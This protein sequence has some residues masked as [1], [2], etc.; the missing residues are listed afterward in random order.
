[1]FLSERLR[2]YNIKQL[3]VQVGYQSEWFRLL[4]IESR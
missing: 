1:M 2:W 3:P 4:H